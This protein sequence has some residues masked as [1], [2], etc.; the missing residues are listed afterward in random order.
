MK[1]AVWGIGRNGKNIVDFVDPEK[2]VAIID[3]DIS[4]MGTYY[5]GIPIVSF[6][7][8]MEAYHSETHLLIISPQNNEKIICILEEHNIKNYLT[9]DDCPSELWRGQIN[10]IFDVAD[11]CI[12]QKPTV[13]FGNS[14]YAIELWEALHQ[15]NYD[16]PIVMHQDNKTVKQILEQDH[17][18][19]Y[20][21]SQYHICPD[22]VVIQTILPYD[23]HKG[24]NVIDA[25]HPHHFFQYSDPRI[26]EFRN[27]HEGKRCFIIG[28]GPSLRAEDLSLL[29]DQGE[30]CFGVNMILGIFPQ[31]KWRP[32]YYVVE[33]VECI[34][35]F[36]DVIFNCNLPVMFLK[37]ADGNCEEQNF[38]CKE[39]MYRFH[40]SVPE[41]Y[42]DN[43]L[44][45]FSEEADGFVVSGHTVIYAC[46]QFAVYMGFSELYLLGVDF[47]YGSDVD[48]S[49][50]FTDDYLMGRKLLPGTEYSKRYAVKFQLQAYEAARK[51]ADS[52]NIKIY[53]ATR[54]GKLEVFERVAFDSLIKKS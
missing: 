13:L 11:K 1:Y 7:Q 51:Y 38:V 14:L 31:T 2:V 4:L 54:G 44:T 5:Q 30:I 8:Y 53:N 29:H 46:M 28:N 42:H 48:D 49:K 15:R 12:E 17:D 19:V 35:S 9:V 45:E 21:R 16:I 37:D 26:T 50:Y 39:G 20:E 3:S 25:F 27:I 36:S 6:Q 47:D 43:E 18:K 33:D 41:W 22:D 10:S 34:T 40:L 52:H 24:M 32:D 23:G